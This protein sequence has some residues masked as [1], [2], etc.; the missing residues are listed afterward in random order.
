MQ[1]KLPDATEESKSRQD[2][3]EDRKIHVRWAS[4][5]IREKSSEITSSLSFFYC[6]H[7]RIFLLSP[8]PSLE[9]PHL[10]P[11]E[12]HIQH[13]YRTISENRKWY[14]KETLDENRNKSENKRSAATMH[15]SLQTMKRHNGSRI[16]DEFLQFL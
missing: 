3:K 8:P 15:R 5:S 13:L 2:N 4:K 12:D 10:Q 7:H 1:T 6:L 11:I 16:T 9:N 14:E